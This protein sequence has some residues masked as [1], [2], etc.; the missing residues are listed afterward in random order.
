MFKR[1]L[2]KKL[3][4][5]MRE[6]EPQYE[7]IPCGTSRVTALGVS[8]PRLDYNHENVLNFRIFGANG[9]TVIEFTRYNRTTDQHKSGVYVIP[10]NAEF[11][12]EL[13]KIITMEQLK[14]F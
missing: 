14:H 12:E 9:G 10:D 1:W 4:A 13:A 8:E 3:Y 11:S 5:L 7:P 6:N 2:R